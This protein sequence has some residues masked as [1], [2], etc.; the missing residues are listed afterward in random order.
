MG[1]VGSSNLTLAGLTHNSELNVAVHGNEN[2][3]QLSAWFDRLWAESTDFSDAL[4]TELR[5][6]W[7]AAAVTPY[8]IFMKTLFELVSE[9]MEG[10]ADDGTL[11][12]DELTQALAEFQK[13]AVKKGG[14]SAHT[15][16]YSLPT[17]WASKIHRRAILKHFR[18]TEGCRPLIICP[19][20]LKET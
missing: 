8:D 10:P 5:H 15:A 11:W 2:H 3:A 1:I 6:C 7:A 16:A 4:L 12:D 17:W 18:R 13:E 19:A 20:P 9:R 14:L